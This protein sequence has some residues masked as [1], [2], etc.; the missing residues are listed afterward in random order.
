MSA[1]R[2][3]DARVNPAC[4]Q[5]ILGGLRIVI[6]QVH[7]SAHERREQHPEGAHERGLDP[8]QVQVGQV[9]PGVK[10]AQRLGTAPPQPR[11]LRRGQIAE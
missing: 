7:A 2:R 10:A 9:A 6:V 8:A 5:A 1:A 4:A 3:T 11:D